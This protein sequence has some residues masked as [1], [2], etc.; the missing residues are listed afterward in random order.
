MSVV[1]N[2]SLGRSER[3]A[4]VT[5]RRLELSDE[6]AWDRFVTESPQG[7]FFHRAGWQRIFERVFRLETRFLLAERAG[8]VAGV[9]PLVHQRSLLF[10][11]ALISSPFCAEGGPIALDAEAMA[12]LDQAAVQLMQTEGASFIEFRSRHAL[13]D[14]WAAKT[15]AYATFRKEISKRDEDN[16]AAIPRR[17][18]AYLRKALSAKLSASRG[19]N[20]DELFLVLAQSMRNLGTPMYPRKYFTELI[21]VFPDSC[22]IVVVREDDRPVSAMLNF[23]FRDTVFPYHGGGTKRAR[24][25]P[26]NDLVYWEVMRGAARRG[27]RY[28]DFGRSR[29]DS[30]PF[31]YK[32]GWGFKPDW[33]EYEYYLGAG[34]SLPNKS[35]SNPRY[36]LAIRL[37]QMLPVRVANGLGPLLVRNLG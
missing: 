24:L 31:E 17:R 15:K 25:N 10:G 29:A 36:D 14:G 28:F 1:S 21:R 3:A 16:F 7:T 20:T 37:W 30:G 27:L 35:P 4:K 12:A 9:L 2:D 34:R 22:D 33:L 8:A 23:Y 18:R 26:A 11:N 6:P 5:V 19:T 13:R 32:K